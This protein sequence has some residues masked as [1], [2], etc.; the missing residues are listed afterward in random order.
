MQLLDRLLGREKLPNDIDAAGLA[1]G[2]AQCC[3]PELLERLVALSR[4][5]FGWFTKHLPRTVEY[6]WV[7]DV[8]GSVAGQKILDIGAGVSPVPLALAEAGALVTTVDNSPSLV[9]SLDQIRRGNEWGFL[10]YATLD[11]RVRSLHED[12]AALK[13]EE[14]PFDAVYSISV[15][16]HMPA[17]IR[18]RMF[19]LIARSMR[20]G[21]SLVLTVDL[22]PQT[23]VLWNRASGKVVESPEEHGTFE[24]MKDELTRLGFELEHE[25]IV[26]DIPG[27]EVECAL[28]KLKATR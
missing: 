23:T 13:P 17:E 25:A 6:P 18:R 8:L 2:R 14:G 9:G 12:V 24:S 16:E 28:I 7:V 27:V 22:V 3:S 21:G 1:W 20:R 10:D 5:R 4:S 19:D 26:R 11:P 15:I